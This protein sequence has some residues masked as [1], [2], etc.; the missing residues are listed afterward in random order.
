MELQSRF[1]T[2]DRFRMDSRFLEED[3][4]KEEDSERKTSVTE[5]DEAL[6]EERK[7]NLSILQS[8]LGSSQQTCSSKTAVK[9]KTFRDVSALHYDPSREEHA[10]FETKTD[11]TKKESKS[12]RRKKR[13]E[14]QKLPDVSKEIFYD[15][16]GD[17]KAMFGLTKD[18]VAGGEE[19]TSWD[20]EEEVEE[21]DE[22]GKD[23][24][25]IPLT[26]LLSADTSAKTEESSGFK[27]S[28]FG[29]DTETGSTE[30]AEYK[31][32]SIQAPKV[33]WQQDPRLQDSSSEEEEE[34]E[35]EQEHE[36]KISAVAKTTEGETPLKKEL[37]FFYPEDN[38][39]TEGPRLFCRSSQLEEQ[40]EQWEEMRSALRQEY[41]KKHKDAR[42]KLKSSHRS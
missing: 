42:R 3:E 6:E 25:Q 36:E 18:D 14:A 9:A 11:E 12:A 26:S 40:R 13:E 15:V 37:F 7:K 39:L 34:E 23:E 19:K 17:L 27:F 28:F 8:V 31:V 24:E 33:S 1:G 32:E 29:D 16:T 22:G 35:Q 5:E 38:R 10:A 2:D 21:V 41:R 30:T 20:Q 4:G